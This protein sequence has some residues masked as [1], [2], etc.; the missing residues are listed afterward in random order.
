MACDTIVTN[1][2]GTSWQWQ[3][4]MFQLLEI[5]PITASVRSQVTTLHTVFYITICMW[6]KQSQQ[7]YASVNGRS[8][9]S[10]DEL[11]IHTWAYLSQANKVHNFCNHE[12]KNKNSNLIVWPSFLHI[13]ACNW[14]QNCA[15]QLLQSFSA[16]GI[17]IFHFSISLKLKLKPD[18]KS[19]V[20]I[21][22]GFSFV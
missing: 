9:N 18:P 8:H 13:S 4:Q 19:L 16:V 22:Y 7:Y 1:G 5:L 6:R 15:W 3:L 14:T 12:Y 11:H 21:N 2:D 10:R 17:F 20:Q